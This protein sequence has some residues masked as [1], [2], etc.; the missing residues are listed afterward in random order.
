MNKKKI[1]PT[2][3]GK[4]SKV[5]GEQ[6]G[7]S[8]Q[9]KHP[10]GT[11]VKKVQIQTIISSYPSIG[12]LMSQPMALRTGW[13]LGETAKEVKR[14]YDLFEEERLA[15]C[16][17]LG[18]ES[19][20]GKIFEFGDNKE[21]FDTEFQK[22]LEREVEIHVFPIRLAVMGEARLPGSDLLG[23]SWIVEPD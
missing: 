8:P 7:H 19:E 15:L 4:K 3:S 2:R 10:K 22:L 20:D 16:Q 23:L 11:A 18:K 1:A 14:V 17:K 6:N 9:L 12:R 5:V 21:K 13:E